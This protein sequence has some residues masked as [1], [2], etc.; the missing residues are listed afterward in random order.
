MNTIIKYILYK[1]PISL[2]TLC[3]VQYLY[4]NG[5]KILPN[6]IIERNHG[7]TVLPTIVC[8]NQIYS[9]LDQ[10]IYFYEKVTG[11]TDILTKSQ[12]W[13]VKNPN[14]RINDRPS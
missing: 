2:D 9:G 6:L 5:I 10:V 12:E 8:D 7:F 14:Y 11:I 3:I 13:K 1:E 4:S